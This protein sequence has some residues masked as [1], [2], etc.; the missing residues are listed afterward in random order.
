MKTPLH[1]SIVA[2]TIAIAGMIGSPV[3][4]QDEATPPLVKQINNGNWLPQNEA[5][6]LRD[7]LFYQRAVHAYMTMRAMAPRRLSAKAT[8]SCRSGRTG[9][10]RAPGCRRPTPTSSIP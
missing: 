2:G 9:W 10:T 6:Q 4:A 5:E 8:T 1:N 7:E 3:L